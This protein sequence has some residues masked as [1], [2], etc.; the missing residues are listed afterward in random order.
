MWHCEVMLYRA[1]N[2]LKWTCSVCWQLDSIRQDW[3]A[4]SLLWRGRLL[5][6]ADVQQQWLVMFGEVIKW[7]VL[8]SKS[9]LQCVWDDLSLTDD[10]SVIGQ[11]CVADAACLPSYGSVGRLLVVV[12]EGVSLKASDDNGK[13]GS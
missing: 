12:L 8:W 1:E 7:L 11:R 5:W 13:T 3:A 6:L 10:E 2:E 9:D 4:D